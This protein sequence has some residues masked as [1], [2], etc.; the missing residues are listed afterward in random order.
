MKNNKVLVWVVVVLAV[1]LVG[2]GAWQ[3]WGGDAP[4]YAVYLRTGDLYFG[5][6]VRVPYF[7]LE[8]VYLLQV[9][10]ANQENPV[11]VQ[12][13]TNVFWGPEDF[14]K[15]NRDEV[16]WMTRVSDESQLTQVIRANPDLVPST[17]QA[18]LPQPPAAE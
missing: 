9:N 6:L 16:V 3:L 15:I 18:P 8:N 5:K 1:A 11:S 13:F 14:V 17:P 10:A 12:K 4:L 7:G 2:I